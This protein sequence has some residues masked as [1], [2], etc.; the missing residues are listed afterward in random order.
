[1]DESLRSGI[2]TF[3][4]QIGSMLGIFFTDLEVTDYNLAKTS[5]TSKYGK[6]F[7]CMLKEGIYLPPSQFETLFLS[8]AHS[9]ED[10]EKTL[11]ASSCAFDMCQEKS[12]DYT[13][14]HRF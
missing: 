6:F 3:S 1:M 9:E 2:A 12:T 4:T 14:F 8:V 7:R 10:I 11:K 13:D 5:D